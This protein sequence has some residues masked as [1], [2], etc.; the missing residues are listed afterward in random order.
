MYLGAGLSKAVVKTLSFKV[1]LT[2][3]KTKS[4]NFRFFYNNLK[5]PD[6]RLS[7]SRKLLPSSLILVVSGVVF[8][9]T[10]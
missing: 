8:I 7:H 6:F 10:L 3:K 1:F 5:N 4:P 2:Q 9:A